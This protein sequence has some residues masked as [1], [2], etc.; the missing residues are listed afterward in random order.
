MNDFTWLFVLCALL[1]GAL[2]GGLA[3]AVYSRRAYGPQ[4][5]EL[6]HGV[7]V[8]QQKVSDLQ[9]LNAG[10]DAEARLLRERCS[11]YELREEKAAE[12]QLQDQSVL[13]ALAPVAEQLHRVQQQVGQLERDRSTQF[14]QLSEQLT[15]AA[16][17][18]A[19]ILK[20]TTQLTGALKAGQVRGTWGE[21]QLKRIVE[22]AGMLPH[23]DFK[24][25]VVTDQGQRPDLVVT[26][27]GGKSIIVDSKVPLDS[28]MRAQ[29]LDPHASVEELEHY[30]KL[31]AQHAKA[32]RAHV[33]TLGSKAY[34]NALPGSPEMVVC[35]LPAESFLAE[36]LR[37]DA[38]LLEHA[39][40]KSVILASP[41]SLLAILKGLAV[42]WRQELLTENARELFEQTQVLYER[43]GTMG[44]HVSQLG[45][46]LKSSVEKYNSFVGALESRVLPSVRRI[47]DLDPGLGAESSTSA[48]ERRALLNVS[49][50]ENAPRPLTA[51]ELIEERHLSDNASQPQRESRDDLSESA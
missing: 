21:V 35:F 22:A 43:L 34:W 9:A 38:T 47:R 32:L 30:Q 11:E 10:Y 40:S 15:R 18:D 41:A 33:D 37:Q 51:T 13:R 28:Y 14:G 36:A 29:D 42:A 49:A 23:V 16:L 19:E 44:T 2:I 7:F 25:Q 27:P 48:E 12:R 50:L 1:A 6:R 4:L 31:L 5:D 24:E 39:F 17:Q 46:S 45:R 26:L 3:V 20:S 8:E